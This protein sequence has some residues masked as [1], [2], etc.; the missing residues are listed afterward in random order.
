MADTKPKIP[1]MG[2]PFVILRVQVKPIT[3]AMVDVIPSA[4]RLWYKPVTNRNKTPK[5]NKM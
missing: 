2:F 1:L 5:V 4:L 3:P